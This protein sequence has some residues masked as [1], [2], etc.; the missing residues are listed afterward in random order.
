VHDVLRHRVSL[1]YEA[2]SAGVDSEQIIDRIVKHVGMPA[3][4]LE[5]RSAAVAANG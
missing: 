4:P 1:T 5:H 2:L 3:R